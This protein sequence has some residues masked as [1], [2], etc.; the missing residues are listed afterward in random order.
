[1][2]RSSVIYPPARSNPAM[3]GGEGDLSPTPPSGG[4]LEPVGLATRST[5]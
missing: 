3:L 2:M 4:G 5:R 1:M